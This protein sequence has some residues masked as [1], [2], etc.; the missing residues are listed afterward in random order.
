MNLHSI[1]AWMLRNSLLETKTSDI[2]LVSSKEFL[3]I[4]A[5]IKCRF[6]LKRV[7]DMIRTCSQMDRT[8]RYSEHSSIIWPVWLNSS[9]FVYELSGCRFKPRCSHLNFRFRVCFEQRVP[10]RRKHARHGLTWS[11]QACNLVESFFEWILVLKKHA[12]RPYCIIKALVFSYFGKSV[13][14]LAILQKTWK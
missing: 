11:R 14:S 8:D 1:V 4:H 3:D 2:A 5:T 7:R 10:F 13:F 9:V 12:E 6:I